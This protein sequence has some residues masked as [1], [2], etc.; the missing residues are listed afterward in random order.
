MCF[1][2]VATSDISL[3]L[4]QNVKL[5]SLKHKMLKTIKIC[6]NSNYIMSTPLYELVSSHL[7]TQIYSDYSFLLC[8]FIW[9]SFFFNTL[10]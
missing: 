3:K 5:K 1:I 2:C 6:C 7:L 9:K 10:T 8:F 4:I